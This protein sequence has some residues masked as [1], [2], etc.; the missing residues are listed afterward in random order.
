[1]KT[2]LAREQR[3]RT[4]QRVRQLL[5][6]NVTRQDRDISDDSEEENRRPRANRDQ[7][8]QTNISSFS[9]Y[10]GVFVGVFGSFLVVLS[11]CYH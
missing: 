5:Q 7:G 8:T 10:C 2:R 6:P 9:F 11:C 4:E 3:I 1:M